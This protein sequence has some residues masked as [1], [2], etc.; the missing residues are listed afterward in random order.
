LAN[1]LASAGTIVTIDPADKGFQSNGCARM[2]ADLSAITSGLSDPLPAGTY[3]VGVDVA[4]GTWSA[5][6]SGG[7]TCYWSRLSGFGGG[8]GQII[9]NGLVSAPAIVTI[10]ATDK[11]F[12]S[13]GCGMW[14]KVG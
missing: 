5:T 8:L 2:S 6:P 7:A 1:E 10:A 4:P 11:G 13:A 3:I 12:H 14:V 9:A